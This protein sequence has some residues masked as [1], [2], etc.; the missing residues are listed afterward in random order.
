MEIYERLRTIINTILPERLKFEF[1][2]DVIIPK[3]QGICKVFGAGIVGYLIQQPG[4]DDELSSR[5]STYEIP[6]KEIIK[7]LGTPLSLQ[8]ILFAM[9][10]VYDAKKIGIDCT[11]EICVMPTYENRGDGKKYIQF[12]ITK[13]VQEQ[14]PE[15]LEAIIS[16]L[17]AK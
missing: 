16:I 3:A 6:K 2:T 13:S 14:K 11:G 17:E 12:D 9:S 15:V 10:K 4:Y 7:I 8:D 5:Y 1:G